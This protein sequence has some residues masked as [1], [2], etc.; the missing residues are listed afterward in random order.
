LPS[1][2]FEVTSL[3]EFVYNK[4]V[5]TIFRERTTNPEIDPFVV[6]K[7]RKVV[8]NNTGNEINGTIQDFF[9][10]MGDVNYLTSNEGV[11]DNYV[12]CWFDD[13][14]PEMNDAPRRLQGVAFNGKVTCEIN[15]RGKRTYNATF[16]AKHG[17]L[18]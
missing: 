1:I 18:K 13:T 3:A 2:V 6:I 9:R 14:V 16:T 11:T 4:P 12:L 5:L 15:E 10:L 8:V 17:K 7:A